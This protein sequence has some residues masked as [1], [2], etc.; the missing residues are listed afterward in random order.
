MENLEQKPVKSK[1]LVPYSRE[2]IGVEVAAA[3]GQIRH[4]YLELK[5]GSQ[6]Q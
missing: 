2:R 4:K 3:K 1:D 5:T 6:L